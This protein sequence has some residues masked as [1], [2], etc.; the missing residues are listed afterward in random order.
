M[1]K[2]EKSQPVYSV[3]SQTFVDGKPVDA[4]H[5]GD[6]CA[7]W[8][9]DETP[10]DVAVKRLKHLIK[11]K[12]QR[13]NCGAVEC[14]R[15]GRVYPDPRHGVDNKTICPFC[16][17]KEIKQNAM[18]SDNVEYLSPAHKQFSEGVNTELQAEVE[19]IATLSKT[20]MRNLHVI[21]TTFKKIRDDEMW[22]ADM[23]IGASTFEEWAEQRTGW[24]VK[25]VDRLIRTAT[26][27]TA[28]MIESACRFKISGL[29]E[30][31]RKTRV[32]EDPAVRTEVVARVIEIADELP[33]E[34]VSTAEA[35]ELTERAMKDTLYYGEDD[36][37]FDMTPTKKPKGAAEVS[38]Y[39][40]VPYI[41]QEHTAAV[42]VGD[43]LRVNVPGTI[44]VVEIVLGAEL[45]TCTVIERG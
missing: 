31:E 17:H 38:K 2:M 8:G 27:F 41:K 11:K 35:G 43:I 22:K 30:I 5:F 16:A 28:D 32:L 3:G 6:T 18:L 42:S 13:E 25:T 4:L 14:E 7:T 33:D 36:E 24:S 44:F 15:C 21:G 37:F 9:I 40:E 39:F 20:T 26:L 1:S 10:V 19:K 23:Q 29:Y 34:K 12:I 45:A